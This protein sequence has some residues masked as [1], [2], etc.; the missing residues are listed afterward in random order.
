MNMGVLF[1]IK[2]K[3]NDDNNEDDEI[4]DLIVIINRN[5]VC[6]VVENKCFIIRLL[7]V[8]CLLYCMYF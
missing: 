2:I 4:I 1:C 8:F 3:N 7:V 6:F 5:F